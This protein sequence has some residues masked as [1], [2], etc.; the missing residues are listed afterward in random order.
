MTSRMQPR[1]TKSS[2]GTAEVEVGCEAIVG[3]EKRLGTV[4]KDFVHYFEER[5]EAM[6][7][8]R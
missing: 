2:G 7:A 4:A 3:T 8:R 6:N 5:L 1:A